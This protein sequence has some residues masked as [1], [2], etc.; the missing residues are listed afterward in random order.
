MYEC[1]VIPDDQDP[2]VQRA[3][4]ELEVRK[5]CRVHLVALDLLGHLDQVDPMAILERREGLVVLENEAQ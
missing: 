3:G 5:E 1:Q 2:L 4:L